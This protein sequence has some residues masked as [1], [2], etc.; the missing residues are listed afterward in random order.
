[1]NLNIIWSIKLCLNKLEQFFRFLFLVVVRSY[2]IKSM[3]SSDGIIIWLEGVTVTVVCIIIAVGFFYLSDH[4]SLWVPYSTW[5]YKQNFVQKARLMH[6]EFY[7]P[8]YS[9][10]TPWDLSC[11]ITWRFSGLC[12]LL[13]ETEDIF[14]WEYAN[15][16]CP[17]L[18]L[19]KK[20]ANTSYQELN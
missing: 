2:L 13:K 8:F 17:F 5:W 9:S 14:L 16:L 19:L 11:I 20:R 10:T 7:L 3:I 15:L 12:L 6:L 18:I 4:V 1:M